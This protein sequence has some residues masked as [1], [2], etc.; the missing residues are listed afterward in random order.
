MKIVREKSSGY[1]RL[2]VVLLV[3]LTVG[4][5]MSEKGKH[6]REFLLKK[7]TTLQEKN[8]CLSTEI[9]VMENQVM[10]LRTDPR[11]IERV[12]KRTLGMAR[13]NETVYIFNVPNRATR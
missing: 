7:K 8:K 12:A 1:V 5:F 13:P 4:I 9:R 2:I 10:L 11:M 6:R 3:L